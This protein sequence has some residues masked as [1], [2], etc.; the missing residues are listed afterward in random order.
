MLE[1]IRAK[2]GGAGQSLLKRKD[3]EE[4]DEHKAHQKA[5][6]K[7]FLSMRKKRRPGLRQ[8]L[9]AHKV[10]KAKE[11]RVIQVAAGL[12]VLSLVTMGAGYYF[13]NFEEVP[14]PG[15][16][17]S[18]ALV[19]AP[20]FINP[21]LAQTDVDRDIASLVFSGLLSFEN[22]RLEPDLAESFTVSED[23][24]VYEFQ[25]R[26]NAMWHDDEPFGAD[27]VIFTINRIQDP[28]FANPLARTFAGVVATKAGDYAVRIELEEPFSPF[29]YSLTFGI[30]PQHI[31]K[32]VPVETSYLSEY[33]LIPIGTGPFK[34]RSRTK[35]KTMGDIKAIRLERNDE[36]Y[37]E[38]ARLDAVVFK[39]FDTFPEAIAAL[40]AKEASGLGFLPKSYEEELESLE[41]M[42]YKRLNLAQYTA[43]FF[44]P[45]KNEAL[46]DLEARQALAHATNRNQIVREA[47]EGKGEVISGPILPGFVGYNPEIEK[48]S[49]DVGKANDL[50]DEA[51]W[52]RVNL[53]VYKESR[54]EEVLPLG[55]ELEAEG[56]QLDEDDVEEEQDEDLRAR[57]EEL[58]AKLQ[59]EF[60]GLPE[61]L[62]KDEDG[63]YLSI[64]LTTVDNQTSRDVAGLIA[65]DWEKLGIRVNLRFVTPQNLSK[66]VIQERNYEIFLYALAVGGDPDP[67]PF[68]HSSQNEYP[69]LNL[70]VFA[71][72]EVDTL[73]EEARAS[74]DS[75]SR[76]L[77]YRHFQNILVAEVPAIFLYNPIYT[78][79]LTGKIQ[80]FDVHSIAG[81]ADRM[82]NITDWHIKTRRQ[83]KQE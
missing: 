50:L 76:N 28:A 68:W 54:K 27:D 4:E 38:A 32:D 20:Q 24:K 81:P 62:R 8:F 23:G 26:K 1:K 44:N 2:I 77:K 49:L 65:S 66:D 63:E 70:S 11:V 42:D 37:Q 78:Y 25:L 59:E 12:I 43:L 3:E 16:E 47:L 17:Y 5:D 74:S 75:E 33:N 60:A 36:Y 34:F 52:E 31:W 82:A 41:G 22:F 71:N 29:I 48:F 21:V 64:T 61:F 46:E 73:L 9:Y 15:G 80:G 67:Y 58:L 69:G 6:R 19:G 53:E 45:T 83:R 56:P 57:R 51:G 40:K 72:Q 18:E 30:L 35:G 55:P 13:Q 39:F 7:F 79:P 14:A 10:M